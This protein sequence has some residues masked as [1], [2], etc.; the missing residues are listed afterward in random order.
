MN[1]PIKYSF[2][3]LNKFCLEKG[4]KLINDYSN[5]K[6]FGS[7]KIIFNCTNCNKINTKCF[8]YLIKRNTLCKRCVTILSFSKQKETML[9]KYGVEHASKS[10]EI[11]NKIKNTF[12]EKYGVDN[13]AKLQC[14]KD[15]QKT[16]NLQRYGVEYTVNNPEI[17]QKMIKTNIE[18]YGFSCCLENNDIK[19]KIK[20][21]NLEKF[22]CENVGQN[23]EIQKKMK[24]TMFQKYK[25]HYPLQNKEIITN[26]KNTC[27]K[28]YGVQN[29][30]QN[31]EISK[32]VKKTIREKYGVEYPQ[33]S[34][35]IRKKTVDTFINKFGCE[36]PMQ[37]SEIAEKSSKNCYKSKIFNFPSGNKIKCQGYEPFALE[38]LIKNTDENDII[39]GCKNVPTIWY[40]DNNG[41]KHR[42]YVDIFIPSQNKCIEVKSNW[43]IKK[44]TSNIFEKQ[45]AAKELGYNYEI[46][47]YDNKGNKVDLIK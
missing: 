39:T 38:E 46:W 7:T 31:K 28:K 15:K 10:Q 13:P 6:L 3:L 27:V 43:T 40:N 2:E 12:F 9:K 35:E 24:N 37:N 8:T 17:K 32:K 21:S 16:T 23:Y 44:K 19:Q 26:L 4:V 22:G 42:H 29:P 25:V 1:S 18:K 33:Q 14:V 45:N 11:K 34:E 5:E 47:V 41:K 20:K 30:L 36:N